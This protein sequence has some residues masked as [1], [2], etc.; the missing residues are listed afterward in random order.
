[1]LS[2]TRRGRRS[3]RS[4]ALPDS[5][6]TM[7]SSWRPR[8]NSMR[9]NGFPR[10]LLGFAQKLLAGSAPR[11]ST[12]ISATASRA[13]RAEADH[14]GPRVLQLVLGAL[15]RGK[16]LVRAE[17]DHP[18]DGQGGEPLWKLP[19]RHGAAISAPVEVIKADEQGAS[20]CCLFDQS[21]DVLQEPE[22][23]LWGR[24]HGR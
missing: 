12:A 16:A 13:E 17:R 15:H 23:L 7:R 24:V 9:R 4:L 6:V 5:T 14:L 21:L 18:A 1:M 10:T 19:H 11:T 2:L 20:Q 22:P 8:K 3:S